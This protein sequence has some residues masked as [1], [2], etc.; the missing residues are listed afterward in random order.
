LDIYWLYNGY[1]IVTGVRCKNM[2][3]FSLNSTHI[4]L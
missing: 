1:F 4:F 3:Y 2:R